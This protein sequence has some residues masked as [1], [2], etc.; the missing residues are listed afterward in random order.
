[1]QPHGDKSYFDLSE[2]IRVLKYIQTPDKTQRRQVLLV[3]IGGMV[4][5]GVI[6]FV[7]YLLMT[8]LPG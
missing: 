8:F 4:T 6:E 1:M 2:Y 3:T 7:I 5:I